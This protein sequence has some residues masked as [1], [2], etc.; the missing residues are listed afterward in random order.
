[1]N[2]IVNKTEKDNNRSAAIHINTSD[3]LIK[4]R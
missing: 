1:M 3:N 4:V 2:K